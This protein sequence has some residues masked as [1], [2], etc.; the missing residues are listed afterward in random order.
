MHLSAYTEKGV[1]LFAEQLICYKNEI[2]EEYFVFSAKHR[3]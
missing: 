3:C 1:L 2:N